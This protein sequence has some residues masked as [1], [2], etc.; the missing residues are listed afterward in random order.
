[1]GEEEEVFRL[2]LLAAGREAL[3]DQAGR[4]QPQATVLGQQMQSD[5][6]GGV[7]RDVN[8]VHDRRVH[9]RRVHDRRV[10][11]HP[12]RGGGLV[13]DD[14]VKA[15]REVAANRVYL[16][17]HDVGL[18]GAVPVANAWVGV[19]VAVATRRAARCRISSV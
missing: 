7:N 12:V 19:V 14:E 10:H 13:Q 2:D 15:R 5:H 6:V 1:M 3:V 9:D 11:G 8:L 18:V 17:L 4:G 16:V